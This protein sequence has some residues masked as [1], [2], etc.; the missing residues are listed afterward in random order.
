MLCVFHDVCTFAPCYCW[1]LCCCCRC[2]S[3]VTYKAK[4]SAQREEGEGQRKT[5]KNRQRNEN[6]RAAADTGTKFEPNRT[7][8][9]RSEPNWTVWNTFCML[10]WHCL[11]A[12][13]TSNGICRPRGHRTD[14][15]CSC[16][17]C[18][19]TVQWCVKHTHTATQPHLHTRTETRPK[20]AQ[21]MW[22]HPITSPIEHRFSAWDMCEL[23]AQAEGQTDRRR[24][25]AAVR[26]A[27]I[28]IKIVL[29]LSSK[30]TSAEHQT[31]WRVSR[32]QSKT[33][34]QSSKGEKNKNH[35]VWG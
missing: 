14:I 16:C 15:C 18:C 26:P 2:L 32:Q 23:A 35:E 27:L 13:W 7:E 34:N 21:F 4:I 24:S 5:K 6:R 22:Q 28:Q 12:D 25:S 10:H 29:R 8:P 9:Y 31:F 19:A 1:L 30:K 33:K 20:H 3:I 11:S 17:C